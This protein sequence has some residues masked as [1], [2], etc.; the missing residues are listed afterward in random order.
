[1]SGKY[2]VVVVVRTPA[3]I[4]GIGSSPLT[5]PDAWQK[6]SQ[7]GSAVKFQDSIGIP[8]RWKGSGA[9]EV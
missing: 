2:V 8:G 1:M 4:T 6:E 5:L 7:N 9:E 3:Q